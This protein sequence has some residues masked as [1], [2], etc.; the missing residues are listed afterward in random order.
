MSTV[1]VVKRLIHQYNEDALLRQAQEWTATPAST[2]KVVL[3]RLKKTIKGKKEL[4]ATRLMALKVVCKQLLHQCI[5]TGNPH[6][7]QCAGKKVLSRLTIL[8]CHRKE[9][10]DISRGEDLFGAVSLA[11]AHS[12]NASIDFLACLLQYLK[13]WAQKYGEAPDGSP[14]VYHLSYLKLLNFGV[15]F[16]SAED[17]AADKQ[18]SSLSAEDLDNAKRS[19][20]LLEGL[21]QQT[22]ADMKAAKQLRVRLQGV[23]K[24]VEKEIGVKTEQEGN[25]DYVVQLCEVNDYVRGVLDVCESRLALVASE[26]GLEREGKRGFAASL[27]PSSS[28]EL[29]LLSSSP[30]SAT[31]PVYSAPTEADVAFKQH[32]LSR[33]HDELASAR[34]EEV[35]LV[36]SLSLRS[37]EHRPDSD[38]EDLGATVDS[39]LKLKLASLHRKA[40]ELQSL[41]QVRDKEHTGLLKALVLA[42]AENHRLKTELAEPSDSP[43]VYASQ[44]FDTIRSSVSYSIPAL[45]LKP[46]ISVYAQRPPHNSALFRSA[47]RNSKGMLYSSVD[48]EV[49]Y[50]FKEAALLLYIGN[51]GPVEVCQLHTFVCNCQSGGLRVDI[52]KEMDEQP[53]THRNKVNRVLTIQRFGVFCELP[54]LVITYE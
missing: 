2:C 20:Q 13:L 52:D 10:S 21:L 19:A 1:E 14:T 3:K 39:G 48:I 28:S 15:A 40:K 49:G 43:L 33:L 35:S 42:R 18:P 31:V 44:D 23:L 8:A 41:L 36:Q 24:R 53:I 29:A 22:G 7:L 51:K 54:R 32:L 11:S 9:S 47:I 50:L 17:L 34:Q 6:F 30:F 5:L 45:V 26:S 37:P 12:R 4:P 25:E 16:P 46:E 27:V 38:E